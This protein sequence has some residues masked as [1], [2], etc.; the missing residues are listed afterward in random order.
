MAA[1]VSTLKR[2]KALRKKYRL[3]EYSKKRKKGVAT[4]KRSKKR[5][6]FQRA[7]NLFKVGL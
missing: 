1:S 6:S 2:L 4:A 5:R 7:T 3:G